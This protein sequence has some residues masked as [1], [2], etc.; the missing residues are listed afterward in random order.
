MYI[1]TWRIVGQ[2]VMSVSEGGSVPVQAA[3]GII[4]QVSYSVDFRS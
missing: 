4:K 1:S 3:R 2:A